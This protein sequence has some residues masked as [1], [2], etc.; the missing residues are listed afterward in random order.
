MIRPFCSQKPMLAGRRSGIMRF[1]WLWAIVLVLALSAMPEQRLSTTPDDPKQN[2]GMLV[3]SLSDAN[4]PLLSHDGQ[5][6]VVSPEVGLTEVYDVTTGRKLQAFRVP[7]S[8]EHAITA[9]G[10]RVGIWATEITESDG[11]HYKS[12]AVFWLFDVD[13][14]REIRHNDA[15]IIRDGQR[16]GFLHALDNSENVSADLQLVANLAPSQRTIPAVTL[17]NLET[18]QSVNEFSFGEYSNLGIAGTVTMTPDARVVAATRRDLQGNYKQT[19][20]WDATSGREL[21]RL[22]FSAISISLSSD[23]RKLALNASQSDNYIIEIWSLENGKRISEVGLEFGSSRHI[24]GGGVLSPDGKLLA[25]KR[26]NYILLWDA[27]SGKLLTA[28]PVSSTSEDSLKSVAF[29]GNG[30]F[31]ATATTSEQ[32]KVWR[33][34]DLLTQSKVTNPSAVLQRLR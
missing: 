8:G 5:R 30:Q 19:V 9:D 33:L 10:K 12:K 13:S 29:S 14:G 4:R 20:A 17:K 25:T 34:S 11:P 1:I 28:H 6:I 23:G 2:G 32:V 3:L 7:Q 18:Q 31:I 21:L 15:V 27:D 26:K 22:P 16:V 24:I